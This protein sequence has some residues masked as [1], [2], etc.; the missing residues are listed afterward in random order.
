L[1]NDPKKSVC[2][3]EDP[4]VP[5]GRDFSENDEKWRFSLKITKKSRFFEKNA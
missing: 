3:A 5:K 4:S 1:S 2:G